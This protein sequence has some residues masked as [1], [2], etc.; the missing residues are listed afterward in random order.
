MEILKDKKII[1][2]VL[3][4]VGGI[5]L[6]SYFRKPKMNSEGFFNAGGEIGRMKNPFGTPVLPKTIPNVCNLPDTFVREVATK[7]GKSYCARFDRALTMTPTGKGFVYRRQLNIP[8]ATF[9]NGNFLNRNG[10]GIVTMA[11]LINNR[12]YESAF[13]NLSLCTVAPPKQ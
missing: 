5:A 4:L 3:A 9:I 2:G 12:D 7:G 6:L 8:D 13:I 10:T 11:E 1:I